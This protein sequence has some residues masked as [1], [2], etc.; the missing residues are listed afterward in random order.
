MSQSAIPDQ[1]EPEVSTPPPVP[2]PAGPSP[3]ALPPEIEE[4]HRCAVEKGDRTYTDP[5]TGYMVFT[6][7]SHRDRGYCCG[8]TCRHCPFEYENVG[9]K[10]K[11]MIR[12][13]KEAKKA[14]V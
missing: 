11:N 1:S 8:N 4:L 3:A 9:R 10:G 13:D 14:V 5:A 7:L 12:R 2:V 6:A